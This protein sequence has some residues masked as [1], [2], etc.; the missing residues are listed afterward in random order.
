MATVADYLLEE[1]ATTQPPEAL[2]EGRLEVLL[3]GVEA[4]LGQLPGLVRDTDDG[5]GWSV[6]L[7]PERAPE[8]ALPWLAQF[9]GVTL[10]PGVSVAQQRAEISSPPSFRRGTVGAMRAAA[11][12]FLT[13]LQRVTII[14][15]DGG[16]YL[17]TA[18]TYSA[19]T[20]N[21]DSVERALLSQKPAGIIL[22]YVVVDGWLIV[23]LEAA[24]SGMTIADVEG[25]FADIQALESNLP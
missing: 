5:P 11:Q 22:T 7:D 8:W 14:E 16:P 3:G 9:A 25:D 13:G 20:P 4:A 2:V 17:A 21:P 18:L 15:Q 19:E 23:E 1:L 12:I 6:L 10:T 24:Y